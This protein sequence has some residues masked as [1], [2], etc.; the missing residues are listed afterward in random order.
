MSNQTQNK[1]FHYIISNTEIDDI[2][3]RFISYKLQLNKVKNILQIEMI[4]EYNF[5][6][7]TD[8]GSYKVTTVNLPLP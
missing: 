5:T 4:K 1:L 2:Q 7:H 8:N 6:F 3:S